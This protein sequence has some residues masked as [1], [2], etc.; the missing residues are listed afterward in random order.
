MTTAPVYIN[1][2]RWRKLA[3]LI[4][5]A[6]LALSIY[7]LVDRGLNLGLDFTGGTQV[8]LGFESDVDLERVRGILHESG[9]PG[10]VVVHFGSDR[11]IMV[12]F[13][14]EPEPGM[15]AHL[16]SLLSAPEG[17]SAEVRRM[18]FV[19]PQVGDEL[20]DDGGLAILVALGLVMLYVSFRF[21]YK[22]ALGAVAALIHDVVIVVGIFSFFRWEVD[23]TVLAAVLAVIGYSLNDTIIISDRI[24]ENLRL[25]RVDDPVEVINE[26]LS[27]VLV[28]TIYTSVST[29]LVL[30]SLFFLGGE[31]IHN[32]ATALIIGVVVGTLS[33]IYV[34]A[35]LLLAL[36]I[37]REDLVPSTPK[38]GEE[39]YEEELP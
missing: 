16:A 24:R 25:I 30:L 7:S 36:N 39:G 13:Q 15:E 21:Q 2:M 35:N 9:Y 17:K 1:Y 19:G 4:S 12:K 11:E 28:R 23:L 3:T 10:A 38:E 26:S 37:T 5:V 8:E 6:L 32:F 29:L 31:M 22:F 14:R 18:E 27:Q 20:R 33:S 34:S